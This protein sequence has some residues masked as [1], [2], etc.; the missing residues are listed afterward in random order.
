MDTDPPISRKDEHQ[1][2]LPARRAH[3]T[4]TLLRA[5]VCL[6]RFKSKEEGEE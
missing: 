4:A 6:Q 5:M 1:V 2:V 3:T